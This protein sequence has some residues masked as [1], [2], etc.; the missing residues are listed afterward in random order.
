MMNRREFMRLTGAAAIAG[1]V[2]DIALAAAPPAVHQPRIVVLVELKGGNDGFNTLIPYD[3]DSYYK[4]RPTLGIRKNNLIPL[5]DGM[6]MNKALQPLKSIWDSGDLAW[7]QG[8]G[9]PGGILSHFRSMDIWDTGAVQGDSTMG[10]LSRVL[11][12]FKQGLH[13]IAISPDQGSLGPLEGSQLNT[14]A[15][16]SPRSFLAN[17]RFIE[18]VPLNRQTAALAH[19]TQTQHQLVDV[20]K[21]IVARLQNPRSR[22]PMRG[23]KGQLGH[24]LQSVAE[25]IVSGIDAPVYKVTQDGFDTHVGQQ[26]T[27]ENALYQVGHG[28]AA[29]A[30]TMKRAGMWDKV[31]VMTYSEFGRRITENKGRGTDH[32]TASAQLIMGGRVNRGIHGRHPNLDRVD[33]NGNVAHT[34][35]FR[36]LYATLAQRW[37]GQANPWHGHNALQFV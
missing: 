1:A 14:V 31:L 10:W 34:T 6:G 28:L 4:H 32:G 8:V 33:A 26:G 15:M 5:Q 27:Q 20:G 12:R 9:Y 2:P 25:M 7:V 21:Q 29:F 17:A 35:D 13:G 22:V 36:A 16:Q 3:D 19:V 37:W 11:P 30:E 24:G 23:A 18:E